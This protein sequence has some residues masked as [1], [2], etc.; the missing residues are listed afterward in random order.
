MPS[1]MLRER[2][3]RTGFLASD[4]ADLADETGVEPYHVGTMSSP[5]TPPVQHWI[6]RLFARHERELT[7][8]EISRG[9]AALT[10]DY[11]QKRQRLQKDAFEGRGKRAAFACYYGPVHFLLLQRVFAALD[12]AATAPL[13]ALDLGCGTGVAG[14]AWARCWNPAPPVT[15]V[16]PNGWSLAEARET[17]RDLG[18][19]GRPVGGP[20]EKLRWPRGP[21]AIL[22]AYVVNELSIEGRLAL[23][24]ELLRQIQQGS[25]V[26]IVE[27][28]ATRIVPWWFDWTEAFKPAGGRIDEWRYS[29]DL[30]ERV[31]LLG[32]AGGLD[33]REHGCR[34]LWVPPQAAASGIRA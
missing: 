26:F 24:K 21:Q 18:L 30:P 16:E 17:W 12:V 15:G 9:L 20:L 10:Q 33:P 25:A 3:F 8:R 1:V 32:K 14:A 5:D 28:L 29:L 11:V 22:G 2:L 19:Q 4:M 31:A 23:Q 7:F 27:P 13:P 6:D 34:T